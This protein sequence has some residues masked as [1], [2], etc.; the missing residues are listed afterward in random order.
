MNRQVGIVDY[1]VGNLHSVVN[2][3][4]KVGGEPRIVTGPDDVGHHDRLLLPGVGAFAA[5]MSRLRESGLD[6]ALAEH[7]VRGKPLLGICLGMQL[8]CRD[9]L[10]DGLHAGLGWMD[11]HVVPFELREGMKV[12]HMGWNEIKQKK[13]SPLL[14]GFKNGGDVYFVHSY[15][16][17]CERTEDILLEGIY[18]EPF[19]AGFA[20]DN[21]Y[22]LQF[23]PEKSQ[24][25]GLSML[26]NFLTC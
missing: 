8:M 17:R 7:V 21:L 1:G 11:A 25:I 9:S 13:N 24:S 3:F 14:A 18:G 6:A 16:A 26:A 22:G 10:E 20:Q 12:P 2:A 15:H 5:A 23:H 19:V 4:R